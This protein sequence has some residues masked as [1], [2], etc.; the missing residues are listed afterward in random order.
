VAFR[1][2][3]SFDKDTIAWAIKIMVEAVRKVGYLLPIFIGVAG[4]CI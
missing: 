1:V 4:L 2:F 3:K